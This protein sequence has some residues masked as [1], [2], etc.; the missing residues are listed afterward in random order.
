MHPSAIFYALTKFVRASGLYAE[1]W[2]QQKRIFG[3]PWGPPKPGHLTRAD[4]A[5]IA[6]HRHDRRVRDQ[7]YTFCY[8]FRYAVPLPPDSSELRLPDDPAV[9]IFAIT[10]A[11]IGTGR[12][13]PA[14]D[15]F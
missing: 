4:I 2:R 12:L 3:R 8:L 14:T 1:Q 11:K 5:W 7:A 10:L 15:L 9:K 13:V 6:T